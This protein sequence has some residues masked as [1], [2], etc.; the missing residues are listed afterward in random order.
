MRETR[1]FW[2]LSEK[3]KENIYCYE[4]MYTQN[5]NWKTFTFIDEI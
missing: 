4:N 3:A 5:V 2:N 1:L